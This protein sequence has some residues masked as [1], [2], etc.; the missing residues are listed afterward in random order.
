MKVTILLLRTT[1][2]FIGS[3]QSYETQHGK[4]VCCPRQTRDSDRDGAAPH[5]VESGELQVLLSVRKAP[6]AG[7]CG[8]NRFLGSHL[9]ILRQATANS[10]SVVACC[11]LACFAMREL[12]RLVPDCVNCPRHDTKSECGF[13][14]HLTTS[15]QLQELQL[16]SHGIDGITV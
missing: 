13:Q 7:T 9:A 14:Q 15:N 4:H 5:T 8:A 1:Q 3:T 2:L 6:A 12:A 11:W 10:P 16:N